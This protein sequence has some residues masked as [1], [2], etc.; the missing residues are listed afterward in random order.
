MEAC[1]SGFGAF[2]KSSFPICELLTNLPLF[3]LGRPGACFRDLWPFKKATCQYVHTYIHTYICSAV[4]PRPRPRTC[5]RE[6]GLFKKGIFLAWGDQGPLEAFYRLVLSLGLSGPPVC[7]GLSG[8]LWA[9]LRP[10]WGDQGAFGGLFSGI[11]ALQ[12]NGFPICELLITLAT[13]WLGAT[14]GLLETLFR[15]FGPFKRSA[16]QY[17]SC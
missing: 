8:P 4:N 7:L 15:E 1:F 2:Q 12:K 16:S 6:L 13:F 14:R 10:V 3:G 9:S 17:V 11:G 5:F